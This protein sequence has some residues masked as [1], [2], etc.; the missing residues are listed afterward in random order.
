MSEFRHNDRIF[1]LGY[2][3]SGKSELINYLA[4]QFPGGPQIFLV[5][6]K[7]EFSIPDVQPISDPREIDWKAPIVHVRYES[8]SVEE[9]DRLFKVVGQRR[10]ALVVVHELS[11]LCEYSANK[12]PAVVSGYASKGRVFG[13]GLIGGTQRP[14]GVPKR[15]FTDADHVFIFASGFP[16]PQDMKTAAGVAG[17]SVRELES[18]LAELHAACGPHAFLHVDRRERTTTPH[19]PLGDAERDA[20][21]VQRPELF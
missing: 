6:T 8:P 9:I 4:Q 15:V 19:A 12:A 7:P 13:L 3:G 1:V 5:D 21:L 20:I 16:E 14:V 10:R 2:T 11:D 18:T 17:M